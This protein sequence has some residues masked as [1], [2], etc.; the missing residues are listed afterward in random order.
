MLRLVEVDGK[1][2]LVTGGSRGIGAALAH[3]LADAGARVVVADL[4]ADGARE[5]AGAIGAAAVGAAADVASEEDLRS[6]VALAGE[7]FGPVDL[8]CANAGVS[9]GLG[10]GDDEDWARTLDVN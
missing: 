4:D 9:G 8:F 6:L 10:L 5:V 2:A 3:A 1:V 7:R